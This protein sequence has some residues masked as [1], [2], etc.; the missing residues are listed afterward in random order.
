MRAALADET[1]GLISLTRRSELLNGIR[2]H[3]WQSVFK[4][5]TT[6]DLLH[7]GGA[8]GARFSRD[9][10][11]SPATEA[12]RALAAR[13]DGQRLDRLGAVMPSLF[14]CSHP[15]FIRLAPYE[16]YERYTLPG[17]LAERTAEV[18]VY[19]AALADREGLSP[20]AMLP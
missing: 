7:L 14:N 18:S 5:M 13:N 20:A 19:L 1:L 12:L 8:Y 6:G 4:Q 17:K 16:Q 3:R 10:W 11:V 2:E 9:P 15:H